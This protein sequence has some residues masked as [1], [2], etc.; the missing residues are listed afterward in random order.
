MTECTTMDCGNDAQLFLC[1]HCISDLQQWIEK[2]HELAPELD[3]T[4]ARR[5]VL[6][7]AGNE[8]GQGG[9]AGSRPP[10]NLH[11][12]ELQAN[13]YGVDRD[14]EV[15]AHDQMAA[16]WAWTIQGW[17]TEAERMISGPE[18][19]RVADENEARRRLMV[20]VPNALHVGPLVEWLRVAHRIDIKESRIRKWAERRVITRN[21]EQGRPTY[22]PATV[23]IQIRKDDCNE[24]Q[25]SVKCDKRAS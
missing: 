9:K 24:G 3:V 15:Y 10:V 16:M 22:D 19:E 20:E 25:E 14:A 8:G 13:L 23:L 2:A 5:D 18:P 4:I 11:A 17:V 6:R 12:V 7:K 21:N 1:G